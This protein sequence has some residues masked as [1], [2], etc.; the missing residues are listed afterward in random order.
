[1]KNLNNDRIH[2]WKQN[3][4]ILTTALIFGSIFL[5]IFSGLVF[6]IS[7]QL[8]LSKQKLATTEAMEIA[9]AGTNY[10]QWHLAHAPNDFSFSGI[11]D[12]TD[13]QGSII[14]QYQ[15][16]VTAPAGCST[17]VSIKS[18][19]W[20][21]DYPNAKR[22]VLARFGRPS[23]AQY[24][25]LTDS[26][27]W[28]GEDEELKGPSHSNGGI[29]MDGTQNALSTSAKPNYACQPMHGCNPAQDKPGIWGIG[30]GGP[31]G[32]WSF[33][34]PGPDFNSISV[35]LGTLKTLA[36]NSGYYISSSS[37]FGYHIKFKN[38]GTFDL[39]KVTRVK[40]PITVRDTESN[41]WVTESLDIDRE[42]FIKNYT[43]GGNGQC[44]ARNLI[45]V[46]EPKVWVDG[47]LKQKATVVAARFPESVATNASIVING[48]ITRAD[49]KDTLL[50]LIAQKNILVPYDSPN[51]FEV[52][53]VMVA[54]KGA[55]KRYPYSNTKNKILVRGSIITN[56]TWTWSYVDG[57]GH[58]VSGYQNTESYYE[59]NLI[60]APPPF[61]PSAGEQKFISWEETTP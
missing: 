13:P 7:S 24:S 50:G 52:H 58:T 55:V 20:T 51:V 22:A 57:S 53:A 17:I 9:E 38:D 44:D 16:Q 39:Y 42:T 18:T 48:N 41:E 32:L 26:D 23:L 36:I 46:E 33:P 6:F 11:Y 31:D 59:P 3:G 35:D 30:N 45:F 5:I 8:S 21:S 10:S 40:R 4:T 27:V 25:F 56:K 60:Y 61:F 54:Q 1:M 37:A 15:L 28:F 14:G 2:Y 19:G 12:Y 47:V 49:P 43:L 34:K 29:R